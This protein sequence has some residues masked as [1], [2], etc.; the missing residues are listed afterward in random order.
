MA[1][2]IKLAANSTPR[3]VPSA[4]Y[5]SQMET[6]EVAINTA[7]GNMWVKHS[8]GSLVIVR[9]PTGPTGPP[10]PPGPPGPVEQFC[11]AQPDE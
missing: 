7:N 2:K 1:I 11:A 9:G 10:G 3:V 6:G 5:I 8:N 4:S